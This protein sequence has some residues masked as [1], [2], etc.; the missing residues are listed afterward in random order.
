MY[1]IYCID[2]PNGKVYVGKTKRS[3]KV[4]FSQHVSDARKRKWNYP[5]YNAILKYGPENLK[6]SVITTCDTEDQA[7]ETE[8]LQISLAR[9]RDRRFGYNVTKGGEGALGVKWSPA[10]RQHLSKMCTGRTAWNK[11]M[12][13]SGSGKDNNFYGRKHTAE[14]KLKIS[15][16]RIGSHPVFSKD[17]YPNMAEV[18]KKRVMRS[19]GVIFSSMSEAAAAISRSLP[20]VSQVLDRPG[21]TCAGYGFSRI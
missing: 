4:R 18:K 19:D 8:R 10:A 6:V 1:T 21:R 17:C 15:E 9:S 2:F 7:N 14:T 5:V 20:S 12:V 16:S 3:M 11:G 13:G